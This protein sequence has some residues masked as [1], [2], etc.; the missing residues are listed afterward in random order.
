MSTRLE[1][2]RYSLRNIVAY[3]LTVEP[4]KRPLLVNGSDTTF[5]SRQRLHKH[6][7]TA[8]DTHAT[9]EVLLEAECFCVVRAKGL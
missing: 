1:G 8:T 2:T 9:I 4:E 6:V 3:L 7:P 5:V